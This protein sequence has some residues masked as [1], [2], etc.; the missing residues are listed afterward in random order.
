MPSRR[1]KFRIL[2][3]K[4]KNG[5]I[6]RLAKGVYASPQDL[7]GLEGD[8]YRAS[9]LCGR[10]SVICLFSA[11]QYYGLSNQMFG[12]TWILVPYLKTLSKSKT[13]RAVR[14]RAPH[15]RIGVKAE[16]TFRITTVERTIVDCFRFS[17]QVGIE[18]AIN[19]LRTAVH[20]KQTT[21]DKIYLIAKKLKAAK[22][23]L[24]YLESI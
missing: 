23:I 22:K 5:Q 8:F 16:K 1:T 14:S 24:P 21:K 17:R 3:E 12:G 19:A 2:A 20:E 11:L 7:E 18:T 6:I 15:F 4:V 10:P 13:I 9:V